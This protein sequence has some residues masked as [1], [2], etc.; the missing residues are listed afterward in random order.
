M[1]VSF[2]KRLKWYG[3]IFLLGLL[4][5]GVYIMQYDNAND[6]YHKREIFQCSQKHFLQKQ[7]KNKY[8]SMTREPEKRQTNDPRNYLS[9]PQIAEAEK[10]YRKCQWE[11]EAELQELKSKKDRTNFMGRAGLFLIIFTLSFVL[12]DFTIQFYQRSERNKIIVKRMLIIV[13]IIWVLVAFSINYGYRGLHWDK[14]VRYGIIPAVI[15]NGLLWV[16]GS[17]KPKD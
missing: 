12:I 16:F 3:G 14:F 7:M 17:F 10:A 2:K 8:L 15:I 4:V 6:S 11:R 1:R 5:F 13:S 9:K